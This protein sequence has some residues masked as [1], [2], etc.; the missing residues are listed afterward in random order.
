MI[1]FSPYSA[2]VTLLTPEFATRRGW[3]RAENA[4]ISRKTYEH[5]PIPIVEPLVCIP[6]PFEMMK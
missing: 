4:H 5:V 1:P 3:R 6:N 2:P